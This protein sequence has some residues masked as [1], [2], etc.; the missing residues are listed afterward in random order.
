MT[1]Q[2]R[3]QPTAMTLLSLQDVH[4]VKQ[5]TISH[6]DHVL[7]FTCNPPTIGNMPISVLMKPG[8]G[9]WEHIFE[10]GGGAED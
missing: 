8:T 9:I 6:D 4:L 1:H 10:L 3:E 5:E 2:L 7:T